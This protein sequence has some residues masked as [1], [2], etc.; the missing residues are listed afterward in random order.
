MYV[1]VAYMGDPF[2]VSKMVKHVLGKVESIK[3]T[4]SAIIR[5]N[6]VSVEQSKI[7]VIL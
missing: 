1:K 5:I 7:A 3:V 4:R 2:E 6:W